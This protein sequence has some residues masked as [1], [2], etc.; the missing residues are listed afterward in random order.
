VVSYHSESSLSGM[1]CER[2]GRLS[3]R[4]ERGRVLLRAPSGFP[5]PHLNPLPLSK[6]RGGKTF[7]KTAIK[8]AGR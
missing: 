6:G 4:R 8:R 7:L 1:N 2:V 5:T 3:L